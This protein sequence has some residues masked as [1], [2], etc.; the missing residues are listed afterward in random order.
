[1]VGFSSIFVVVHISKINTEHGYIL[2]ITEK[3]Q[4]MITFFFIIFK[5]HISI[6]QEM[7]AVTSHNSV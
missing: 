4:S 3:L 2:Q 7:T 5:H 1:M 6:K